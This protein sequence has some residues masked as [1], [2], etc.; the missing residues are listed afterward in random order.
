MCRGMQTCSE[1]GTDLSTL[2]RHAMLI[3]P[4]WFESQL[5]AFVD[6]VRLAALGEAAKS[7]L[8]LAELRN[9]ELQHWYIEHAQLSG[10]FRNR[11]VGRKEQRDARCAL[12]SKATPAQ[13]ERFVLERDG[14]RCRYCSSRVVPLA[15][16]RALELAVGTDNFCATGTNRQRHGIVLA[17][18]ATVDHV[19]P[20]KRG[21]RTHPDNL[22]TSCFP[23]N[24]GKANLTLVEVALDDPRARQPN[25]DQWDGL[26][27]YVPELRRA[28]SASR[29]SLI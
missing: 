27:R 9:V 14:F 10:V 1:V 2:S 8:L 20:Y 4:D 25:R 7:R 17:F 22:V 15:V 12:D 18:R 11:L 24:F 19:V 26:L 28:A 16:L 29:G 21:G 3:P 6:A 13:H 23:C 5:D